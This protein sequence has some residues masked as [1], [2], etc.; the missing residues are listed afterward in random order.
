MGQVAITII[1][2]SL[3][4]NTSFLSLLLKA[5]LW[6]FYSY[7][8]KLSCTDMLLQKIAVLRIKILPSGI[9]KGRKGSGR[10]S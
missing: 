7:F 5:C 9:G 6:Y 10:L 4:N 1:H 2:M 3:M 8:L